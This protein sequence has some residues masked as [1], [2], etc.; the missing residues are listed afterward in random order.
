MAKAN[1]VFTHQ[2][3][4]LT[5]KKFGHPDFTWMVVR[6]ATSVTEHLVLHSNTVNKKYATIQ[7]KV[8]IST[9]FKAF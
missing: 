1:S 2:Q 6:M 5:E 8:V 9:R 3:Y 4:R 7:N